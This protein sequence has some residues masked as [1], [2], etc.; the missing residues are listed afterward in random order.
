MKNRAEACQ[1]TADKMRIEMLKL[2]ETAGGSMHWGGSFSCA[3]ILAVL[4][5]AVMNCK[6]KAL[7]DTERDKFIL[8]KGHAS[9]ALYTAMYLNGLLDGELLRTYQQD[10]SYI[11]EL[12]EANREYGFESSGGSLGINLSYA[13][14]MALLA[15]RRGFSY[16]TYIAAGDGEMNEGSMWEAIMSASQHRLDNLTLIVDLN[17]FQS[18]GATDMISSQKNIKARLESFGWNVL[19]VDGHNCAELLGAFLDNTI[20]D[21]PKAVIAKTVK[22][23][24]VSFFEN[25]NSWHDRAIK[26]DELE[27]AGKEVNGLA[28]N[29]H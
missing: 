5:Q 27:Q 21:M 18:D 23:K 1:L 10:G 28:G 19:S 7:S 6:D 16:K 4:F 22:G 14:G 12:V 17:G 11:S 25:N 13:V 20:S 29:E 2:A 9:A 26:K 15:K 24:G 8:S 3:E